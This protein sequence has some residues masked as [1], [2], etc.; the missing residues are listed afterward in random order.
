MATWNKI[1]T[2]TGTSSQFIKGD[3]SLD[4]ST[5][6]DDNGS[7]LG[8]SVDLNSHR[9]T[10]LYSQNSNSQASSG[11]N[12]P[13]SY[14]G[15]L[16]VETDKG[17][18]VHTSQKYWQYNNNNVHVRYYYNGTWRA[19]ERLLTTDD[20]SSFATSS[21]THDV[22]ETLGN[23]VWDASDSTTTMGT[24]IKLSF[25]RQSDGFPNY[26]TVVHFG[27]RAES[28]EGGNFQLYCGHGSS[29]GG[30]HLRFRNADNENNDNWTGWKYILDSEN[31]SSYANFGSTA[32]TAGTAT[33]GGSVRLPNSGKLYL[34][35]D[36]NSN[37]LDY[38][39]WQASASAGMT[40]A[41]VA[42]TGSLI[43]KSGNATAL[44]IDSSQDATFAGTINS[45]AITSSGNVTAS[46]Y[47]VQSGGNATDPMIRVTG[48]T[49]TGIYFPSNDTLAFST[50][51]VESGFISGSGKL[52][53]AGDA[54]FGGNV[55]INGGGDVLLGTNSGGNQWINFSTTTGESGIT[56]YE[57][58]TYSV[59]NHQHGAKLYYDES[60]DRLIISTISSSTE[61]FHI[62]MR[63]A[64]T[65]TEFGADAEFQVD[66]GVRFYD[67][68][69]TTWSTLAN[70]GDYVKLQAPS[71]VGT[72]YT[73]KLPANTGSA[74]QVIKTDGAG[75]LD[76]VAQTTDT[77]YTA[78]SGM[79]LSGTEF[80][81]YAMIAYC[82]PETSSTYEN[83]T[84]TWERIDTSDYVVSFSAPPSGTVFIQAQIHCDYIHSTGRTFY[85]DI[86]Q[87]TTPTSYS[88]RNT[89]DESDDE[90][91]TTGKIIKG[92]VAGTSYTYYLWGRGSGT[93]RWRWGS[94]YG[95]SYMIVTAMP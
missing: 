10:G 22:I 48:D 65:H 58:G 88:G 66:S 33:F 89:I 70:S 21:H 1:A 81:A 41:N 53:W 79:R 6:M 17:N 94:S 71:S 9:S 75:N 60:F 90:L 35:N 85:F 50:G 87:N 25:V 36:H 68:A 38:K 3:G 15:I 78:G 76:W 80:Y 42:G 56:W 77:T 61:K 40:I 44:T 46:R 74:D 63:R 93:V 29:Y 23:Y 72:S 51:G 2:A 73:L 14:A 92:L 16:S 5:Y 49:H 4:S 55:G 67:M 7:E 8:G 86:E 45:G 30:N 19:W 18:G 24:G 31:Y 59:P 37:Y 43:F 54:D 69:H 28:D 82:T 20:S 57:T 91:I 84:S 12:Y 64:S 34:W 13:V 39:T 52:D 27:G 47:Y 95:N 11:S 83:G 62:R 32:L 26:G